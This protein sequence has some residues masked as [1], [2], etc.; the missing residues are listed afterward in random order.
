MLTNLDDMLNAKK[1]YERALQL[2]K[3]NTAQ[4]R[5]NYAIFQAKQKEFEKS[6]ESLHVFYEAVAKEST[7]SQVN[8]EDDSE[9]KKVTDSPLSLILTL[10]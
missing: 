3:N 8:Y 10:K 2:D 9:T 1:A 4:I 7:P 6:A 5:L